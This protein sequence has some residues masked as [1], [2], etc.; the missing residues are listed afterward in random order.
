MKAHIYNHIHPHKQTY[1][2]T[3]TNTLNQSS[4]YYKNTLTLIEI[5]NIYYHKGLLINMCTQTQDNSHI[6]IPMSFNKTIQILI[7]NNIN[8]K[9]SMQRKIYRNL[10]YYIL[11]KTNY[12]LIK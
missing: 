8:S 11:R 6:Q 9:K 3:N 2:E 4:I 7:H 1:I 5:D 10:Y 12:S